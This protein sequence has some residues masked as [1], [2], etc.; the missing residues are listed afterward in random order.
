MFKEGWYYTPCLWFTL[1]CLF[2]GKTLIYECPFPF[3]RDLSM[4]FNANKSLCGN[5]TVPWVGRTKPNP[6]FLAISPKAVVWQVFQVAL[7]G[8]WEEVKKESRLY[9]LLCCH[10]QSVWPCSEGDGKSDLAEKQP[11]KKVSLDQLP[12]RLT[13][14][15]YN[16][17]CGGTPEKVARA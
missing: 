1:L 3:D 4:F 8:A 13:T 11:S 7:L 5:N 10:R 16:E 12:P 2:Y 9:L 15:P 14:Q 17:D 6:Q